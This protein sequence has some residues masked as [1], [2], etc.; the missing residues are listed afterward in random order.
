M[1]VI[2]DNLRSIYNTASIF[3]TSDAAGVEKIFLCGTTPTPIDKWGRVNTAF[4]KVS[5][6][7]ELSV[8]WTYAPDILQTIN[9]LKDEKYI[10]VAL[11]QADNSVDVFKY[12]V[13]QKLAMVVGPERTGM[14]N[15]VLAICDT[16][17]E[18]PMYGE[19]E[20]LNVSVA[21]GIAAYALR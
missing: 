15:K 13:P 9:D 6:G 7:A 1:I 5:L 2:L 19:K 16:I 11:E 12:K 3:R 17:V 4:T 10:V 18:I 14:D 8:S 20:S 21:F